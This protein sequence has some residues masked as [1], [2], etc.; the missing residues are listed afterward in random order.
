[1]ELVSHTKCPRLAPICA[2]QHAGTTS[3][4]RA[5]HRSRPTPTYSNLIRTLL[6]PLQTLKRLRSLVS[7]LMRVCH[8]ELSRRAEASR[9]SVLPQVCCSL[10]RA[11]L[12]ERPMAK[13]FVRVLPVNFCVCVCRGWFCVVDHAM[14]VCVCVCGCVGVCCEEHC[15]CAWSNC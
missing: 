2:S 10:L 3:L 7:T 13:V 12:E 14:R 15:V 4:K 8:R 5:A 11:C 1:M 9:V 6:P